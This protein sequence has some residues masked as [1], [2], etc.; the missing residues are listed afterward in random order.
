MIQAIPASY[1]SEVRNTNLSALVA[2][3]KKSV[4]TKKYDY[5]RQLLIEARRKAQ[6]TQVQVAKLL[7]RPQ[8]Y[9][10]KYEGGERRLDVIEFLEVVRVI[11]CDPLDILRKLGHFE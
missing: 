8:S 6:M 1:R 9:V 5:F 2:L 10:S 3:V 7:L 11:K 4:Y